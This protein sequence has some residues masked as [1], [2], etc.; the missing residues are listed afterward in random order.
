MVADRLLS[1]NS[2]LDDNTQLAKELVILFQEPKAIVLAR[3]VKADD[4]RK[5]CHDAD[6]CLINYELAEG[7]LVYCQ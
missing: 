7:D 1:F 6:Q 4:V 3:F 2:N 5:L